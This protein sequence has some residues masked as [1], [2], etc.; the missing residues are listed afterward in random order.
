[1]AKTK[2]EAEKWEKLHDQDTEHLA[3][4]QKRDN[5]GPT[6]TLNETAIRLQRE[7]DEARSAVKNLT[8]CIISAQ[9]VDAVGRCVALIRRQEEILGPLGP[10]NDFRLAEL[11]SHSLQQ[12]AELKFTQLTKQRDTLAEALRNAEPHMRHNLNCNA[13]LTDGELGCT[14]GMIKDRVAVINAIAAVKGGE[15]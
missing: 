3:S 13:R 10:I 1:M 9:G 7:L 6:E 4:L 14:C 8:H 5:Y 2:A 15:A 11:L 12:P